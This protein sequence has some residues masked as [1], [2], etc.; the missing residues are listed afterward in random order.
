MCRELLPLMSVSF[1]ITS[2]ITSS[3][4]AAARARIL[5]E[6]IFVPAMHTPHSKNQNA[7][8][9]TRRAR[10]Q[11]TLSKVTYKNKLEYNSK[12]TI[13]III[14]PYYSALYEYYE[15][16]LRLTAAKN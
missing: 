9:Q 6:P 2:K 16:R 5:P 1:M 4:R 10:T 14:Q 12:L 11:D 3:E 15:I 13:F 7:H 8:T